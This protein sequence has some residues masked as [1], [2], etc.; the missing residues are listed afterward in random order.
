MRAA[1][2]LLNVKQNMQYHADFTTFLYSQ[3]TMH[4][5]NRKT[6]GLY[7]VYNNIQHS[8]AQE[9]QFKTQIQEFRIISNSIIKLKDEIKT[10]ETDCLSFLNSISKEL[11]KREIYSQKLRS[12][13]K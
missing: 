12:F 6:L 11:E 4:I 5:P 10:A 2:F 1:Y 7:G 9:R 8:N 3:R 13:E